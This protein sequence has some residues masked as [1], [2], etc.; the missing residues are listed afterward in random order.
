M[1]TLTPISEVGSRQKQVSCDTQSS[2]VKS[3]ALK[4]S[5]K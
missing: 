5:G 3:P 2:Q 4:E 1:P